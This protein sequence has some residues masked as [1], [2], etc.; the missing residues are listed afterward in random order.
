MDTLKYIAKTACCLKYSYIFMLEKL[1]LTT[2]HLIGYVAVD[3]HPRSLTQKEV[4]AC[5]SLRHST[6]NAR[7]YEF[8]FLKM[9]HIL[10]LLWDTCMSS[11]RKQFLCSKFLQCGSFFICETPKYA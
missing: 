8:A 2:W 6:E 1:L 9:L 4:T 5:S 10:P 3:T 11:Y 7:Q